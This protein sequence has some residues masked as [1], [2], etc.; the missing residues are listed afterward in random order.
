MINWKNIAYGIVCLLL[1]ALPWLYTKGNNYKM[2]MQQ[3]YSSLINTKEIAALS[4]SEFVYNGI[5]QSMKENGEVDYNVL[6]KS[7]VK[8]SIDASNI[9]YEIDDDHKTVTFIFPEF[10]FEKPAV[11]IKS[12]KWIP[13]NKDLQM[14]EIVALCRDD[15]LTEAQKSEKLIS[16]A[17]DN[18]QSITEAW[19]SPV[20]QGYTFEYN[21][22]SVEGGGIE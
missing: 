19:Y 4:T 20:F 18:L 11:D 3:S 2:S 6:Y 21:F 7:S 14:D 9:K 12:L 1:F 16:S 5:V 22:D 13:N 15:A 10:K 8:V 17:R